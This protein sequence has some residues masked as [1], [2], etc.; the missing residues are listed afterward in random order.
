MA[1]EYVARSAPLA[2][3]LRARRDGLP[4]AARRFHA[5]L[6]ANGGCARR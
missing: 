6:H 4:N 3:T 1:R 2:A 5:H